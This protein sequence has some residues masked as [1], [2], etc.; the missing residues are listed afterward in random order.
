MVPLLVIRSLAELPL[1]SSSAMAGAAARV[2]IVKSA[3]AVL[4]ALV[5]PARSVW[6]TCT[7]PAA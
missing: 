5:L 3:N 4:T 7:W 1:S 2:S 6:R